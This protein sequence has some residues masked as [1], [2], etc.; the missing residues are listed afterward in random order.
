MYYVIAQMDKGS[1]RKEKKGKVEGKG[2][3]KEKEKEKETQ[4]LDGYNRHP[5]IK[6]NLSGLKL[7]TAKAT[8]A[9]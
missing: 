5:G 4:M 6:V 2:K 9:D 7:R 8:W 1:R 3:G